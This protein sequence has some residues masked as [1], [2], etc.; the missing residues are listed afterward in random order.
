MAMHPQ[1]SRCYE[2]RALVLADAGLLNQALV[3]CKRNQVLG[4][5]KSSRTAEAYVHFRRGEFEEMLECT[6]SATTDLPKSAYGRALQSLALTGLG[7]LD[8][9]MEEALKATELNKLEALA[10]YA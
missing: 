4:K 7:R 6:Q 5:E 8:E 3:G 2:E 9:A 10:W 1:L